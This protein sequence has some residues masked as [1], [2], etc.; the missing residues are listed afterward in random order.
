MRIHRIEEGKKNNGVMIKETIYIS[1]AGEISY[2]PR[3]GWN[4]Y[5]LVK[6]LVDVSEIFA[7]ICKLN[8]LTVYEV[9]KN[10]HTRDQEYVDCRYWHWLLLRELQNKSFEKCGNIYKKDHATAM[11]G[12]KKLKDLANGDPGF[13][14]KFEGI[15]ASVKQI[16]PSAFDHKTRKSV[17]MVPSK[18]T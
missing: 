9:L 16:N 5:K 7:E 14:K 6:K 11:C 4:E 12:V 17:C 10:C 13:K 15:I 2:E 3:E 18:K 8:G 1:Q